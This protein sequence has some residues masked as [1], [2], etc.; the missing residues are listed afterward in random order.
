MT[1]SEDRAGEEALKLFESQP[2]F[3][4]VEH[5]M[6][7]SHGELDKRLSP[8]ATHLGT[9]AR[10][11][12]VIE[13]NE[14]RAKAFLQLVDDVKAQNAFSILL[15]CIVRAGFQEYTGYSMEGARPLG[16]E[17]QRVDELMQLIP[18]W[19]KAGY[20]RL[21]KKSGAPGN[22]SQVDPHA[23]K[24]NQSRAEQAREIINGWQAGKTP[25]LRNPE[26]AKRLGIGQTTLAALKRG[27]KPSAKTGEKRCGMDRVRLV[28]EQIGCK[29]EQLDADYLN[30]IK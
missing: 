29:P 14:I 4:L 23:A 30:F 2:E 8:E 18:K 17:C 15:R 20:E 12:Y 11:E 9:Q 1:K 28:A 10:L 19:E 3:A 13:R 27:N 5:R 22:L 7:E 24:T 16:Q 25:R 6:R 26:A 21:A